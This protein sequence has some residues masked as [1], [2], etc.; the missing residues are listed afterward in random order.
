MSRLSQAA[1]GRVGHQDMARHPCSRIP[2][3]VRLVD[4]EE[5]DVPVKV[6]LQVPERHPREAPRVALQPGARVV[7]HLH[8]LQVDRVVRIG[9]MRLALEPAVP[10]Q[11]AV[12]PLEV[13]DVRR[14]GRYPAAHG[15]PHARRAWPPVVAGDRDRVPVDVDGDAAAGLLAGHAALA[16]LPVAHGVVGVVYVGLVRPDGVARL[17]PVLVDGHR[18]EHA[19]PPLEGLLVARSTRTRYFSRSLSGAPCRGGAPWTR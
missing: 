5:V 13:V 2:P 11:R 15:L 3:V 12:G 19:P 6:G 4:P 16:D 7:H 17:D 14:P 9:P 1:V 10:D 8:P 18:C